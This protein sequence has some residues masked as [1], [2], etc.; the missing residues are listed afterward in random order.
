MKW[1]LAI[2]AAALVFPLGAGA[3][4][5]IRI[6]SRTD[7]YYSG[8]TMT[9]TEESSNELWVGEK[10][11][12]FVSPNQKIIV[13]AG[14]QVLTF[15]NRTDNTF[16][17]TPL[18]LD[19][20]KLLPEEE[21]ARLRL[22]AREGT[23]KKSAGPGGKVGERDCVNY[24]LNDWINYE[25][26]KLYERDVRACVTSK[27]PFSEAAFDKMYANLLRLG[28][29]NDAYVDALLA[30]E[31]FQVATEETLYQEGLAIRTETRVAEMSEKEPPPD[32]YAVP[33]GA[34]AKEMLSLQD[35]RN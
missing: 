8:G 21:A 3:D 6:D 23:I 19:L 1:K 10:R 31:G 32:A 2:V 28:G 29:L 20:S 24:E 4:T 16:V 11:L 34:T 33:E 18:P 7:G 12:A 30:M 17:Q 5:Y 15:V 26:G 27:L 9:P 25:G 13:D 14:E 22:F 35:L